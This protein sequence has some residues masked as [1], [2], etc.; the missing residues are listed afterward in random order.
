MLLKDFINE[1]VKAL[2]L[3]YP[4]AE[5]RNIVL[6]LC[7]KHL[8]TKSYTHIIEPDYAIKDKDLLLLKEGMGRLAKGEP[9]QYVISEAEFC[10]FKFR[11]TPDVLIPRPET[12]LLCH[13][14]VKIGS[15][16]KRMREAYGKS[17]RP[18]RVLDLC[19]GSGCVAWTVALMIPGCEVLGVDISEKAVK[20]AS[21]QDFAATLK[22]KGAL[23]P[24]FV[25][26]DVFD[27]G[28]ASGLGSFDLVLSN[29]P[30]IMESEKVAMRPNVLN[31]EPSLALFVPDEDP[32][33]FYRAI[34]GISTRCLTKEGKGISEINETLGKESVAVFQEAGFASTE[35]ITDFYDKNRFVQYSR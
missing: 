18:V 9:I 10:G 8:G 27:P 15:M 16:M 21:G 13:R 23:A 17:A 29:P 7:E 25:V 26:A 3:L 6:M 5:A 35:L 28:F 14:A 1:G 12:E 32:L 2:E 33:R 30:Y 24:N 34:A 20:V 19:T 4:T 11:V 22:A 31:F